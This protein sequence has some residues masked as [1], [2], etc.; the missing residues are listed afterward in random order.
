M[1]RSSDEN[2]RRFKRKMTKQFVMKVLL[3]SQK[4][5]GRKNTTLHC[6]TRMMNRS[7]LY[8]KHQYHNLTYRLSL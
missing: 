2:L 5:L 6:V 8:F 1:A 7:Y 4:W 3:M